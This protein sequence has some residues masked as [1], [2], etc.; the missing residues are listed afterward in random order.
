MNLLDKTVRDWSGAGFK[1]EVKP[2]PKDAQTF[3]KMLI[4]FN[5][6]GKIR[7]VSFYSTETNRFIGNF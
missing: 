3:D 2:A 7:Q 1:V 6:S 5:E 4:V